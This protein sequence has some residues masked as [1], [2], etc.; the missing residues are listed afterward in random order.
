MGGS[1]LEGMRAD[2]KW[3]SLFEI[4]GELKKED[5]AKLT[6]E[7]H[8]VLDYYTKEGKIQGWAVKFNAVATKPPSDP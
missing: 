6:A 8:K 7:V 2:Q 5:A 3:V 1:G 4:Y